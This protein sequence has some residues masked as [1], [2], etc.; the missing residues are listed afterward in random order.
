MMYIYE[1]IVLLLYCFISF[2]YALFFLC[3]DIL[4]YLFIKLK[5]KWF[6]DDVIYIIICEK[7]KKIDL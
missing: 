3:T 4:I 5:L 1:L 7:V 2:V 6:T